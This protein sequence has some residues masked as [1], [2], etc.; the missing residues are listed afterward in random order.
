MKAILLALCLSACG[1]SGHWVALDGADP[2][3]GGKCWAQAESATDRYTCKGIPACIA[4]N[5]RWRNIYESCLM[6]SGYA[7]Q[8]ESSDDPN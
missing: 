1:A 5:M 4:E 3:A 6:G 8:K 7:W 2:Y